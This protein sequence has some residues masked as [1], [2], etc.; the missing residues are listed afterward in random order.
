MS[1]ILF[2]LILFLLATQIELWQCWLLWSLLAGLPSTCW[3]HCNVIMP[4]YISCQH[5]IMSRYSSA[6][7]G[8][9]HSELKLIDW[10]SS[11]LKCLIF[12]CFAC[13]SGNFLTKWLPRGNLN[14]NP[15]LSSPV[16]KSQS[17]TQ[18]HHSSL[19]QESRH[20][21]SYTLYNIHI[22]IKQKYI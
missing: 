5:V 20:L 15:P 19:W 9:N 16:P 3:F 22:H 7:H 8:Y 11:L 14:T 21:H 4:T 6:I 10:L 2:L 1:C 17:L 18:P 13:Q 12:R